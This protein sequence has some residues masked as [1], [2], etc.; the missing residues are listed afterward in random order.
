MAKGKVAAAK[1][2]DHVIP[3]KGNLKLFWDRAN[4]Q[5]LC[6][7]CHDGTKQQ[8]DR[9]GFSKDI[10]VDGWPIDPK[11]PANREMKTHTSAAE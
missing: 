11:H 4:W 6:K 1:I 5:P 9:I 2:V 8:Y 3:H 10:G 7:A